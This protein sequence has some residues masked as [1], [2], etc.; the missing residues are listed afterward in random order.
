MRDLSA[1]PA[2]RANAG[3][4]ARSFQ[5]AAH[6]QA[7]GAGRA[8]S[9]ERWRA[10]ASRSAGGRRCPGRHP[11]AGRGL[12]QLGPGARRRACVCA[13]TTSCLPARAQTACRL[14]RYSRVS[15]AGGSPATA[16]TWCDPHAML[17]GRWRWGVQSEPRGG[18]GSAQ[19][20][21][22]PPHHPRAHARRDGH[23]RQALDQARLHLAAGRSTQLTRHAL[24]PGEDAPLVCER[25]AGARGEARGALRDAA[26]TACRCSGRGRAPEMA[27]VSVL[28]AATR[29]ILWSL[30]A[31]ASWGSFHMRAPQ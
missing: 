20:C 8:G 25:G 13:P 19:L 9:T 30:S 6:T 17:R 12:L 23:V 18:A 27:S 29:V 26:G 11:A 4:A 10:A 5:H 16:S 1:R 31:T 3:T 14:P 15:G 21:R 22:R 28:P 7:R 24:A 2:P